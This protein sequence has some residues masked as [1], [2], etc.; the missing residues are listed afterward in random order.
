[1]KQSVIITGS[2]GLLG[3]EISNYF[4]KNFKV[5]KLDLS[6]GHD[7][8]DENFVKEWFSKNHANYLINC[9]AVNDNVTKKRKK[10]SLFDFS[11]DSFR[12]YLNVNL[13][14]LF[15]V[16]REFSRNN[17]KSSIVNFSS[18]YGAVSPNPS[19]YDKSHKDIGYSVS[20]AGVINM[21]KYLATHLAPEIRVN[22]VVPGGVLQ[23]QDLTFKKKYSKLTPMKRM[24]EKNEMNGLLDFLCSEKS[25]YMT[26]SIIF[27]DGGYTAL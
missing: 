27:M 14:S 4:I 20:K 10:N 21:T 16:C 5:H 12:D 15:S 8:T 1:M 22:C 23:N 19:L 25:S 11:L 18:I 7:L 3:K 13:V 6:L 24:M 9:F 17:K 26:G 2:E